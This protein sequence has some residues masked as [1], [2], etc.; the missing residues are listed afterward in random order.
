[1]RRIWGC[2][3]PFSL[4]SFTYSIMSKLKILM[5]SE[6]S[7]VNSGFG[8]YTRELLS[9]LHR[10]N[11][12]D[13]AEFASYGLVN[14]P[15]D[16]NIAWRYYANAVNNQDP[17]HQEYSSRTDNQFG[18]WRFDKVLL[19]FKP[20]VVIDIRDYWMNSYQ[21][22]SP[23]RPYFNWVLMPTVDSAPQQ[24]TWIST[25]LNADA[26]FTYSDWG[27]KVLKK[28]S[29]NKINYIATASPGVDLTVFNIKDNIEQIK[30]K[31]GLPTNSFFIGSVMRNQ[32]RKLIPNLLYAFRDLLN[33]LENIGHPLKN[34]T[35]LYLHTSYPDAGWDIPELLLETR[36]LNKVYFTYVCPNCSYV[37]SE[38]FSHPLKVC[39]KCMNKTAKLASV[40]NGVSDA[41]LSE[42]YNVF[43]LYV[44]YAICEGFGMP[45]VEAAA[46]GVPIA[47][48][49]YSAMEDII[50]KL[51]AH[52]IKIKHMFK[53]METKAFRASPDNQ[54]LVNYI[55]KYMNLSQKK[56]Q[57]KRQ[58]TRKLAEKY[59]NWDHI[60]KIW[61]TFLD[62]KSL[63]LTKKSWT[64][65]P[66]FYTPISSLPNINNA[67][68]LEIIYDICKNNLHNPNKFTDHTL[69]EM[70][71]NQSYGFTNYGNSIQPYSISN[72]IDQLNALVSMNNQ[73]ETLR[74]NGYKSQ[75]DF[76]QY[77]HIKHTT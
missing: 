17:R 40:T 30:L 29:N 49:N 12:Y 22:L 60:A 50:K 39:A 67:N 20:N 68:R 21:Q 23:L 31:L 59:Y 76:I 73:A 24:D 26:V 14:D 69:I 35:Y 51:D 10:T 75:E 57:D 2:V 58:Q 56:K 46:C 45:Q 41:D 43:D 13:I 55:E 47:S 42:I 71:K 28:Q 53:E 62:S 9:R 44:Q 36:L 3:P 77:A 6:A 70:Y 16:K 48:V 61:E 7:F 74:T 5:C 54:D 38:V 72:T 63:F 37:K 32:K 34:D 33:R 25:F 11:K 66:V 27:A 19:D 1:M 18:R 15:R 52:P 4:L 65:D 64:E 8:N